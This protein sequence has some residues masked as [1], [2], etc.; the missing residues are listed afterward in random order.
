MDLSKAFDCLPHDLLLLNLKF[1]GLS[2]HAVDLIKNYLSSR[3]QCVKLAILLLVLRRYI[4]AFLRDQFYDQSYLTFLL[5][6]YFIL[7]RTVIFTAM[8]MIILYHILIM[9][10]RF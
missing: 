7:S 4:N 1:Y 8:L 3:K 10:Q 6:I 9:I 2:E 5:M